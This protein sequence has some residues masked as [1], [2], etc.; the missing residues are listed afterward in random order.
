MKLEKGKHGVR[1]ETTQRLVSTSGVHLF[2]ITTYSVV[3]GG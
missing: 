2:G 3:Q 1:S